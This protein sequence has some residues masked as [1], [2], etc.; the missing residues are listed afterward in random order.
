MKLVR[1]E[2]G[3]LGNLLFKEAYLWGQFR[4]GLIPDIY[5]QSS[6]YWDKYKEELRTRF[7]HGIGKIDKVALHIRRGDY[8]KGSQFHSNLWD[9]NYYKEAIKLFPDAEFLVFCKDNQSEQQDE[10]DRVWLLD[11][12]PF[13]L[14]PSRYEL[15]DHTTE[16]EDLNAIASCKGIIG[17]NSSFSWWGAFLGDP[18]KQVVM[19]KPERWFTDKKT[20]CDLLPEWKQI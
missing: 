3:G 20:R 11:N 1:N 6:E 5:V 9:T 7:S 8:L 19:P 17:A 15:Y 4:N 2:I 18:K 10:D 14:S 13:L 16:T 12:L